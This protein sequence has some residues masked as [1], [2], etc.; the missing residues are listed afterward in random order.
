MAETEWR[1]SVFLIQQEAWKWARAGTESTVLL[2]SV[3]STVN[4]VLKSQDGFTFQAGMKGKSEVQRAQK[5][6][7]VS[8]LASHPVTSG[9]SSLPG[10]YPTGNTAWASPVVKESGNNPPPPANR[11]AVNKKETNGHWVVTGL[12]ILTFQHLPEVHFIFLIAF[13]FNCLLCVY[14]FVGCV[15]H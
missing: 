7:Q 1:D 3:L 4:F 6:C 8:F 5:S 12:N 9:G 11:G 13:K 14:S 15:H 2:A 10:L